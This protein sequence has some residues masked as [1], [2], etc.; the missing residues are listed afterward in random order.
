MTKDFFAV[1]FFHVVRE[2][3]S[4][5]FIRGPVLW[6]AQIVAILCLEL[7]LQVFASKPVSAEPVQ[8]GELLIRQLI[9]LLVRTGNEA[10]TDKILQVQ[11]RVGKFFTGTRHE[12][13]QRNHSAITEVG[14]DQIG[15][16]NPA[17]IDAFTGLHRCLQLLDH[18]TFLDQ[19][20]FDFDAGDFFKGL[21]HHLGLINVCVDSFGHHVN[22]FY[23]LGFELFSGIDKPLHFIELLFTA[24]R[25][26]L[27]LFVHPFLCGFHVSPGRA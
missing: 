20:V 8:V 17:V 27:E 21:S 19:V 13:G 12:I 18:V 11:T 10:N 26:W 1:E 3:V 6:N 24:Q 4:D 25:R 14:T 16:R 7:V 23:A 22:F 15:I 9:D 2:E 5:I